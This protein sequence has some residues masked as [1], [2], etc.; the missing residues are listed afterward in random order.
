MLGI[1]QAALCKAFYIKKLENSLPCLCWYLSCIESDSKDRT[2]QQSPNAIIQ[3][4]TEG[5]KSTAVAARFQGE[6][7]RKSL[8]LLIALV[9]FFA[10]V[11]LTGT[12]V[13]LAIGTVFYAFAEASRRQGNPVLMVSDL[14]LIASRQ[15]DRGGFVLGPVTLGLGAML[16]L[17]LY[18]EPA[19]SLAI[20]ALAF[21]DSFASLVGTIVKGPKVPFLGGKTFA[22]S[23]ACLVAV[24]FIT[25]GLT[26]Q[27]LP[28]LA[29]AIG[30]M[31]LEAI[32]AGNFDNIIIP[33]GV[34]MLATRL[35]AF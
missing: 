32:P 2:M 11:N 10:A 16:S 17:I 23:F 8:H 20:F 14:T 24:F 13:L 30:A 18:P 35:F 25:F 3:T 31:I 28:S 27:L 19:A 7:I 12:L 34:G 15:K 6:F 9:P 26:R 1:H 22:G 4:A 33:V 29:V 5:F 21:G